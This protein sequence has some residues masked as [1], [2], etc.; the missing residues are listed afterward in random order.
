MKEYFL[1]PYDNSKTLNKNI[2]DH[3]AED[4]E[5]VITNINCKKYIGVEPNKFWLCTEELGYT[6]KT[7]TM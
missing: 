7:I 2:D 5:H 3:N 4:K 6:P 1:F